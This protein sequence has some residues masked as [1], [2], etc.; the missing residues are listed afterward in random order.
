MI[1]CYFMFLRIRVLDKS[2]KLCWRV[3]SSYVNWLWVVVGD[4]P[5]GGLNVFHP[6]LIWLDNISTFIWKCRDNKYSLLEFYFPHLVDIEK[7]RVIGPTS[8]L[9]RFSLR[10]SDGRRWSDLAGLMWTLGQLQGEPADPKW[11]PSLIAREG[12]PGIHH[13]RPIYARSL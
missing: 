2:Y 11:N 4:L 9:T 7:N 12:R 1:I 6:P 13:T 5:S 8:S 3:V 10:C